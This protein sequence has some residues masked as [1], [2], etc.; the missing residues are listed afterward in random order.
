MSVLIFKGEPCGFFGEGGGTTSA[1]Y[2]GEALF[3]Q[4]IEDPFGFVLK[5]E[6][7]ISPQAIW[8]VDSFVECNSTKLRNNL[9]RP[10]TAV[11][12]M[13]E[14]P[15]LK[16]SAPCYDAH[17]DVNMSQE[18][19]QECVA[20]YF[21][22]RGGI[23][24]EFCPALRTWSVLIFHGAQMCA[25]S[26][27]T[28]PVAVTSGDASEQQIRFSGRLES[29]STSL[30]TLHS[31]INTLQGRFESHIAS[32]DTNNTANSRSHAY[33]P[34]A[35][36]PHSLDYKLPCNQRILDMMIGLAGD[37]GN[38]TRQQEA[39]QCLSEMSLDT[40]LLRVM[41]DRGATLA[42]LA[43]Y[44]A[45]AKEAPP[46]DVTQRA[47]YYT[48]LFSESAAVSHAKHEIALF[49]LSALANFSA[50]GDA[51]RTISSARGAWAKLCALH[52]S[53]AAEKCPCGDNASGVVSVQCLVNSA[54][55]LR[56]RAMHRLSS[57]LQEAHEDLQEQDEPFCGSPLVRSMSF[58]SPS[59]SASAELVRRVSDMHV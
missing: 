57:V 10:Q 19:I 9:K 25:L 59:A 6:R 35:R 33:K 13:F 32:Q 47:A 3:P 2:K 46:A 58:A 48:A 39:V 24:F 40:H 55:R 45:C 23:T 50:H 29:G 36:K 49:A 54:E 21:N 20:D 30:E 31:T 12:A 41:H 26:F 27:K 43:A 56:R 5:N 17:I 4:V 7:Q 22:N 28:S 34:M 14:M 52:E 18:D 53:L 8:D 11:A 37:S 42:L 1:V 38:L 44:E 51:M 15:S 16:R